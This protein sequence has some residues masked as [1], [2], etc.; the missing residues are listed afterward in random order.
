[1]ESPTSFKQLYATVTADVDR[2]VLLDA[3]KKRILQTFED[4]KR[5][6]KY[7]NPDEN[8]NEWP[9]DIIDELEEAGF[10]AWQHTKSVGRNLKVIFFNTKK[11]NVIDHFI[12]CIS[13]SI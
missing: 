11:Q 1:M 13:V 6:T 8:N 7:F 3:I 5:T 10:R 12:V 9:G 4:N 2:E